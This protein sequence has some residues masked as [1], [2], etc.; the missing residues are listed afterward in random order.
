MDT[1]RLLY[2]EP[3]EGSLIGSLQS[4]PEC[5]V[6]RLF[7]RKPNVHFLPSL[8]LSV[9]ALSSFVMYLYAV[10]G[11]VTGKSITSAT[12]E[13]GKSKHVAWAHFNSTC[14]TVP[15]K[16][17]FFV[18][19][20]VKV[21]IVAQPETSNNRNA[22]VISFEQLDIFMGLIRPTSEFAGLRGFLRRSGGMMG[23]AIDQ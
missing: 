21:P 2:I 1:G 15:E 9:F 4:P 8:I 11:I 10:H 6:E 23:S 14:R 20:S 5:R 16:I 13:N 7:F 19:G 18:S 12:N 22:A 17:L 3:A